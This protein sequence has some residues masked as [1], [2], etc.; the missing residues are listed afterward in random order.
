[1]KRG[2]EMARRCMKIPGLSNGKEMEGR[3][4]DLDPSDAQCGHQR[5]EPRSSR[6][7]RRQPS[8]SPSSASTRTRPGAS[9]PGARGHHGPSGA[10]GPGPGARGRGPGP[11]RAGGRA[12]GPGARGS[13]APQTSTESTKRT[14]SNKSTKR[15]HTKQEKTKSTKSTKSTPKI[16]VRPWLALVLDFWKASCAP[17]RDVTTDSSQGRRH[18]CCTP[19]PETVQ[20]LCRRQCL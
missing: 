16:A 11:S 2:E 1:M 4:E 18:R 3:L 20:P 17:R 13:G 12:P 6:W 5:S 15:T 9:G 8:T 10:W 19:S 14:E 7:R